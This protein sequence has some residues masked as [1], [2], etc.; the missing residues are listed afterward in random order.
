MIV[1]TVELQWIDLRKSTTGGDVGASVTV[2]VRCGAVVAIAGEFMKLSGCS[3]S[4]QGGRSSSNGT[5]PP[6]PRAAGRALGEVRDD[7]RYHV[8]RVAYP[9]VSR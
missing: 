6:E 4:W 7:L 3:T 2:A 8:V 9:C 5:V 1:A